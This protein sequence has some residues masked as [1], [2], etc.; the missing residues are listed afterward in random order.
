MNL[1]AL[2][3]KFRNSCDSV[4]GTYTQRFALASGRFAMIDDGLGFQLVTWS[5]SL[6]KHP[7]KQVGGIAREPF[8]FTL[9]LRASSARGA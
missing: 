1:N 9:S 4:A 2:A 8:P 7:G 5:P 3:P 6:E